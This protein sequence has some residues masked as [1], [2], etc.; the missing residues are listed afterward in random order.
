MLSSVKLPPLSAPAPPGRV[1]FSH[2][3]APVVPHALSSWDAQAMSMCHLSRSPT[4]QAQSSASWRTWHMSSEWMN[5]CRPRLLL[6]LKFYFAKESLGELGKDS[7]SWF[8]P[9][10]IILSLRWD[11]KIRVSPEHPG[12]S[13]AGGLQATQKAALAQVLSLLEYRQEPNIK[14][15]S[16]FICLCGDAKCPLLLV[17]GPDV[18]RFSAQG[19]W[20]VSSPW[21]PEQSESVECASQSGRRELQLLF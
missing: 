19:K 8:P 6:V 21:C 3:W 2:L 17:T 12:V 18:G 10:G 9:L 1:D 5:E 15:S 11:P 14:N 13:D 4:S 16:P 7:D 20:T